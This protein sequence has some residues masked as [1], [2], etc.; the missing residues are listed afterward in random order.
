VVI[1]GIIGHDATESEYKVPL[2]GDIPGLGWFFKTHSTSSK[3]SNM[4]IF[5]TP[6][7]IKNPADMSRVTRSKEIE[8]GKGLA[9]A[10]EQFAGLTDKERT[11][12]LSEL[13]YEKLQHNQLPEAK[14]YF[15][16]AL[17]VDPEN[18]FALINLAVVFE[19]E[20]Q[21]GKAVEAYRKVVLSKTAVTASGSSDPN[22]VGMPLVQIA[23]EN[24]R[25]LNAE[26]P[27]NP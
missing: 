3:K 14:E 7:I 13:G 8:S 6:R 10:Q 26:I 19:K 22:R 2:L 5:V 24:L 12:K 20:G 18:P 17:R 23:K 11:L 21:T 27:D 25:R 15:L 16:E 1:G 4:F 9:Q